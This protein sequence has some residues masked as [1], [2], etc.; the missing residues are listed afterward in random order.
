MDMPDPSAA[1]AN[2][3]TDF[4]IRCMCVLTDPLIEVVAKHC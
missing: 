4:D 2:W 3:S 1:V